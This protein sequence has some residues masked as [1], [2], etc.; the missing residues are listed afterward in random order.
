MPMDWEGSMQEW[1]NERGVGGRHAGVPGP[2]HCSRGSAWVSAALQS[3][4]LCHTD[5]P[6]ALTCSTLA[7]TPANPDS[8]PDLTTHSSPL[9]CTTR[10]LTCLPTR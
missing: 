9:T 1:E 6:R 2:S 5:A 10:T 7:S 8:D 4:H 3:P